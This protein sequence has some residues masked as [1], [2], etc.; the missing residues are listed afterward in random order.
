[1]NSRRLLWSSLLAMFQ[2]NLGNPWCISG[3]SAFDEDEGGGEVCKGGQSVDEERDGDGEDVEWEKEGVKAGLGADGVNADSGVTA[4][5][6][7]GG[8]ICTVLPADATG[9]VSSTYSSVGSFPM[10]LKSVDGFNGSYQKR[11]DVAYS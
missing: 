6:S 11:S 9:L 1:M 7:P 5:L 8:A 3:D 4:A 10:P 2:T